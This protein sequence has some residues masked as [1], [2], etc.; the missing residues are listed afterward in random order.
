M[1]FKKEKN[2]TMIDDHNNVKRSNYVRYH[3]SNLKD[4]NLYV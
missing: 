3:R 2:M 4:A 1:E